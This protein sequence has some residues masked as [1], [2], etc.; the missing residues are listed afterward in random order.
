MSVFHSGIGPSEEIYIQEIADLYCKIW[1]EPPWNEEFWTNEGVAEDIKNQMKKV[2]SCL[3]IV[4]DTKDWRVIGFSWGYEVNATDLSKISGIPES[5][6]KEAIGEETAFYID[7][8]GVDKNY[9]RQG[10]GERLTGELL[11]ETVNDLNSLKRG[12][13]P[14]YAILRTDVGALAARNLYKKLG[15]QELNLVDAKYSTR[16]YWLK[17][18]W[19]PRS[20]C[21]DCPFYP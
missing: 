6:W 13:N 10:V 12:D 4:Q 21:A 1:R 14:G 5:K 19:K 8:L 2:G 18:S 11:G 7:E 16:T 3:L 9:R 20:D 17:K 15:F